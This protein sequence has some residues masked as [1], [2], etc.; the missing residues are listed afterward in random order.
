MDD[1]RTKP[2]KESRRKNASAHPNSQKYSG[3][4]SAGQRA[5]RKNK[6]TK[7]KLEKR[8]TFSMG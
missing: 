2:E 8:K 3:L 6:R 4:V 5:E 7:R 1:D